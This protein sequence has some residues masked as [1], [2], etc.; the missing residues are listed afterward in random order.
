M[1]LGAFG[2]VMYLS[3]RYGREDVESYAGL[4]WKAPYAS[5]FMIIFLLSLTGIPPTIGFIGK[6]KL[7]YAVIDEGIYWLAICAA[8]NSVISLFY[9]FRIAKALFLVTPAEEAVS[10]EGRIRVPVQG[11]VVTVLALLGIATIYYGIYWE[12]IDTC[13]GLAR[14]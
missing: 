11:L 14:P 9:Y 12:F 8:V 1:N 5:A 10:L 4:G 2:F 13:A 3:N 7:F 6:W